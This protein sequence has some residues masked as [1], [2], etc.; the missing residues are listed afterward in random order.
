MFQGQFFLLYLHHHKS[1]LHFFTIF[2]P[3]LPTTSVSED[4]FSSIDY[5]HFLESGFIWFLKPTLQEE[6]IGSEP[7]EAAMLAWELKDVI[8][9][10]FIEAR[11]TLVLATF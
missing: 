5:L 2:L 3:H 9:E 11:K 7:F 8:P 4:L 6:T 10:E 1:D